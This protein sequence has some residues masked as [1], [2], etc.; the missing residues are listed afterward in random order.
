VVVDIWR[1]DVSELVTEVVTSVLDVEELVGACVV[2]LT[3]LVSELLV[4]GTLDVVAVAGGSMVVLTGISELV[5]VGALVVTSVLVVVEVAGGSVVVLTV[6][7]EL[8]VVGALVDFDV[9]I[10]ISDVVEAGCCTVVEV[11]TEVLSVVNEVVPACEV[12]LKARQVHGVC[13]CGASSGSM[14]GVQLDLQL[15]QY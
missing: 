10:E 8:V 6:I 3:V 2:A 13:H 7:S 14:P 1:V 11:I 9:V 4:V 12:V 15:D 5:V